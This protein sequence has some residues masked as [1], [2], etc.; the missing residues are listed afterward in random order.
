VLEGGDSRTTNLFG[1]WDERPHAYTCSRW[2]QCATALSTSLVI[3]VI[4]SKTGGSDRVDRDVEDVLQHFNEFVI[5]V[6][7]RIL[8]QHLPLHFPM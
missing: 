5:E 2:Q 7:N 3:D 1:C 4:P 8:Y 6:M